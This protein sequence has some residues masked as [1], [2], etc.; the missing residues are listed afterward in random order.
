MNF[1]IPYYSYCQSIYNCLIK[2]KEEWDFKS[3]PDYKCVLEHISKN[4]GNNYLYEIK[5]H[6][7]EMFNNNKDLIIKLCHKND[8]YGKTN[9]EVFDDFTFCS[10]TNLRYI[11]HSFLI[12]DYMKENNLNNLDIIEIGGGYGGL[13]FFIYNLA[14]LFNLNINSYVIFDLV[15]PTK[16]Q[17]KYLD[18]LD[19]NKVE[20]LVLDDENSLKNLKKDSFL[21]SNYALSELTKEISR[22][23]SSLVINPYTSYGFLTW[24][25]HHISYYD[26]VDNKEIKTIDE[27]PATGDDINKNYYIYY[28]PLV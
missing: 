4:D 2:D 27:Y 15:A 5:N 3:N 10:P 21:I 16:L 25:F 13:C 22:K 28:K 14:S 8:L 17:K 1:S 7:T 11:L 18:A 9:K 24:N 20:C 12:L 19:I 26:F 23:Y 6:F